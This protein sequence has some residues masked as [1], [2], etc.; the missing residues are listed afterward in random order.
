VITFKLTKEELTRQLHQTIQELCPEIE[1]DPNLID[2]LLTELEQGRQFVFPAEAFADEG[3]IN[4]DDF[5][6]R[7]YLELGIEFE[8][9]LHDKF[10]FEMTRD[11]NSIIFTAIESE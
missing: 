10:L 1:N 9:N 2:K 5:I 11:N 4:P 6:D 8:K 3:G 7:L